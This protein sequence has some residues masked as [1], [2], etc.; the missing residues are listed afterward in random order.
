MTSVNDSPS[1]QFGRRDVLRIGGVT[2]AAGAVLAACG[3]DKPGTPLARVGDA[4]STTKL[5]DVA[6]SDVTLLRTA[7]S[8]ELSVV[9]IYKKL[10]GMKLFSGD[11]AEAVATFR[12][13]HTA[14]ANAL[15]DLVSANK[16]E[17]W[18]CTNPRFDDV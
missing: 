13:N 9:E 2:I 1:H 16:G 5:P 14:N 6:V 18:T 15:N 7:A 10:E 12:T 3:P 4:P 17:E 8:L 11:A